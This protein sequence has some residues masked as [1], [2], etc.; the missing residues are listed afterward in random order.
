D[1]VRITGLQ[2]SSNF[3]DLIG[4]HPSLG[5]GFR[6]EETGPTS[7][8]V[9]VLSNQ[10]WKRLGGNE[11]IIGTELKVGTAPFT[12]IGV[13]PQDFEF[14]APWAQQPDVYVPLYDDLSTQ[15]T[16]A[17]DYRALIRARYGSSTEQVRQ[18]I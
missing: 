10:L 6:P 13:M 18:A 5:R 4:V 16:W 14:S 15:P 9:I 17:H 7:P 11:A 2:V 3:F 8:D 12:V 1:A